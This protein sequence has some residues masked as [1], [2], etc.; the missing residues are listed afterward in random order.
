[1]TISA[2]NFLKD[3]DKYFKAIKTAPV[4]IDSEFGGAI[5]ISIEDYENAELYRLAQEADNDIEAGNFKTHEEVFGQI[6][7]KIAQAR[8]EL[9]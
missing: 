6:Y 7:A 5:L 8:A 9:K 2:E 1:M 3:P 4:T